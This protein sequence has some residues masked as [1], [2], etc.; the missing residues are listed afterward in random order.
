MMKLNVIYLFKKKRFQLRF[1]KINIRTSS[2]FKGELVPQSGGSNGK[3]SLADS[4]LI[5]CTTEQNL[6]WVILIKTSKPISIVTAGKSALKLVNLLSL[7]VMHPKRAIQILLHTKSRNFT[8]G[9][10]TN[11]PPTITQVIFRSHF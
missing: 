1:K 8:Y 2:N 11:L 9:V 5:N 6:P 4:S 3:R 7:K 10:G